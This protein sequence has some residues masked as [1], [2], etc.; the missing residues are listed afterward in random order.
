MAD[1]ANEKI[2]DFNKS[3]GRIVD[4]AVSDHIVQEGS[5]TFKERLRE[6]L[7]RSVPYEPIGSSDFPLQA[8]LIV[9]DHLNRKAK[10]GLGA[11]EGRFVS[12]R[13]IH[14]VWFSYI[15]GGWKALV[16]T[17]I[18]DGLYYEV[19]HNPKKGETY[20]D[21]YQKVSNHVYSANKV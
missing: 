19:T 15:L 16:T 14:V 2:A 10:E 20:L 8:G 6:T 11:E 12:L 18:P 4:K 7:A 13:D 21:E 17:S 5:G 9:R 1:S 3:F